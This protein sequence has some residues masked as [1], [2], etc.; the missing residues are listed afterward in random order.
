MSD[1]ALS[2]TDVAEIVTYVAPGYLAYTGFRMRYPRPERSS[3]HTLILSVVFSLPLVAVAHWVTHGE[4]TP[5]QI[6]YVMA[7]LGGA[8]VIG[9]LLALLRSTR[10]SGW[11]LRRIGYRMLPDGSIYAATLSQMS[12]AGMVQLEL[13]DGRRILGYPRIGPQ[14]RE[15]GIDELYIL[16]PEASDGNSEMAA[17]DNVEGVIV[18]LSEVSS[19]T[20]NEDPTHCFEAEGGEDKENE[21]VWPRKLKVMRDSAL[22]LVANMTVPMTRRST[23]R[24]S[25]RLKL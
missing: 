10:F 15:D 18:P 8:A 9:Y 22:R 3:G 1:I 5:T 23:R 17:M 2:A 19:I 11:L 21:T 14:Y 7:L 4:H 12:D 6:G 20:L 24:D 25:R 13:K 16:R